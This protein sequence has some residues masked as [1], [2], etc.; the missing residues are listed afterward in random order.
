MAQI[1][2]NSTHFKVIWLSRHVYFPASIAG[3]Q[4]II[5]RDNS[6]TDQWSVYTS[7]KNCAQGKTTTA[8]AASTAIYNDKH[9]Y[10]APLM[11]EY[12]LQ[13][14]CIVGDEKT[15][16][17]RLERSPRRVARREGHPKSWTETQI[18]E[19][20]YDN[21]PCPPKYKDLVIT[22]YVTNKVLIMSKF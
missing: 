1:W 4:L 3:Q 6:Y 22:H 17:K 9:S 19:I 15:S 18:K 10:C 20:K 2:R 11:S 12:L 21:F 8:T 14:G 7:V 5:S 13:L 16:N